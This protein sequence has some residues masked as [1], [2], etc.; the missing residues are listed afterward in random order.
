MFVGCGV[1]DRLLTLDAWVPE[2]ASA[3]Q[4]DQSPAFLYVRVQGYGQEARLTSIMA[5]GL[6]SL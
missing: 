3:P 2:S 1:K 4:H 5:R 6:D